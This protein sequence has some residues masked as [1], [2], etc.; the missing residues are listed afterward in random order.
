MQKVTLV[1]K[2][3]HEVDF[4]CEDASTKRNNHNGDLTSLTLTGIKGRNF[5][6]IR[7]DEVAAVLYE[8][9]TE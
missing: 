7:L 5:L 8:E 1:M 3:G 2:S 6:Y 4:I 9:S